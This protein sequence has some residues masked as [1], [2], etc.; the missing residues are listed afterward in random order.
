MSNPRLDAAYVAQVKAVRRRVEAYT[1]GR[2]LAGQYRDADL[3]RFIKQ[4]VPAVLAGRRRVSSLTDSHL[5]QTLSATLG[6]PV[7]P[8]GP[9]DTALL[10]GVAPGEVYSRPYV[11]VRTKLSKDQSLDAAINAGLARLSDLVLTD[12]QMAKTYTAQSVLSQ[13]EGINGYRRTLTGASCQLCSD[14]SRQRYHSGDLMPIH[15]GCDCG[16]EPLEGAT[17]RVIESKAVTVHEHGEIGPLLALVGQ[18]FTGPSAI[19]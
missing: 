12:M 4:V 7:A 11:V 9:I 18:H 15:P 5:S 10:R 2:F 1:R 17:G 6:R 19:N 16:V 14:A 3:E 13:T 8:R